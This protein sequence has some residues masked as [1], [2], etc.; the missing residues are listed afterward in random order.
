MQQKTDAATKKEEAE[1]VK[2]LINKCKVPIDATK[3]KTMIDKLDEII[4]ESSG[5]SGGGSGNRFYSS[6]LTRYRVW[7]SKANS[8]LNGLV[9]D[10][11]YV[12]KDTTLQ[13]KNFVYHLE[14]KK[15]NDE[16]RP[17]SP[18]ITTSNDIK[19]KKNVDPNKNFGGPDWF[20]VK[21]DDNNTPGI[22]TI[23]HSSFKC[24]ITIKY[25]K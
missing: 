19:L 1:G 3:K 22:I 21:Y 4:S 24:T 14:Q 25:V 8:S 11:M 17:I 9:G 10:V 12:T 13:G 2:T 7:F 23:S 6:T 18:N 16:W 20:G 5:G 15:N